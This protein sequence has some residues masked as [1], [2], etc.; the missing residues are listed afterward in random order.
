MQTKPLEAAENLV[1]EKGQQCSS[2]L[3]GRAVQQH[4]QLQL[5]LFVPV[6]GLRPLQ[7]LAPAPLGV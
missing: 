6:R 1:L 3:H 5:P 2:T 4:R 7:D